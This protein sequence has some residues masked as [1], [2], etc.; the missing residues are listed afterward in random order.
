MEAVL[1]AEV[2]GKK[3]SRESEI[4]NNC[5]SDP[6]VYQLVR[7]E[8]DGTL[9][10]ATEDEVMQFEHLLEDE[11]TEI[12]S[13]E[14]LA[15]SENAE[16]EPRKLDS[17]LEYIEVISEKVKQEERLLL[18]CESLDVNANSLGGKSSHCP[19]TEESQNDMIHSENPSIEAAPNSAALNGNP[20][21]EIEN[22]VRCSGPTNDA[23]NSNSSLPKTCTSSKPDFSLIEGEVCLD[24]LTIRELQEAFRA[25]FGRQTSVKDKLWLKRRIA[26]GLINSCDVPTSSFSIKDN[27]IV[28]NEVKEETHCT[29]RRSRLE[30]GFLSEDQVANP[31]KDIYQVSPT[32]S[33]DHIEDQ[34]RSSRRLRMPLEYDATKENLQMEESAVKRM[35]KPTRRYIE[36]LSDF[37]ARECSTRL[38]SVKICSPEQACPKSRLR[39]VLGP[40]NITFSTRQ[41]YIGGFGIQVPYVSRARRGRPRKNFSALKAYH[42]VGMAFDLVKAVLDI[43]LQH[44]VGSGIQ[45]R[46]ARSLLMRNPQLNFVHKKREKVCTHPITSER[47][48]DLHHEKLEA[49]GEQIDDNADTQPVVKGGPRRKHHR[50]WTLCEVLKLVDGVAQFGT[51]RW[52]EIRRLAFASYSYRTSVDLKDKW[53]N[54][55][56]ASLAQ[57]PAS[58]NEQGKNSRKHTSVPIPTPILSRVRELAETHSQTGIEFGTSK[59]SSHGAKVVQGKGTGFL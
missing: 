31:T 37:D 34:Q 22:T 35:R 13:V 41:D 25:T 11:K 49:A 2:N 29:D 16:V 46:K 14:G 19:N 38:P 47:K 58:E 57:V 55:L 36:E 43:P 23:V 56:R 53:R 44:N 50:A 27:K 52:S 54:L 33:S 7:V 21:G 1:D 42:S 17:R 40:Q 9:V 3:N 39:P 59:F 6:V 51:G 26:M 5:V 20:S 12:P 30:S 18:S 24:N 48:P 45:T 32:S 28:C 15:Q 8:G 4:G 10:P